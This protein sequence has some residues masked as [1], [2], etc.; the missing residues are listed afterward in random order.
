[1]RDN[2]NVSSFLE[3]GVISTKEKLNMR[4]SGMQFAFGVEG[5]IDHELKDDPRFVKGIFRLR[6]NRNG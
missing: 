1:M 3:R 4:S 6:G 2:P 5:F